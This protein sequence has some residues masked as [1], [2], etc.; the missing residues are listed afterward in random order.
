MNA[1]SDIDTR[2]GWRAICLDCRLSDPT[3]LVNLRTAFTK[4]TDMNTLAELIE[5]LLDFIIT[6][7][8]DGV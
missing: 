8:L 3:S 2:R 6:E 4:E 1:R 7:D 5:M